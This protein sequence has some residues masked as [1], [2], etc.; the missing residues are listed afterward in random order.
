MT[1]GIDD[2]D[3]RPRAPEFA[4][5]P[6]QEL[7]GKGLA[8]IHRWYLRDLGAVG[9]LMGDI[10]AGLAAPEQ[11]TIPREMWN[12]IREQISPAILAIATI[13][14]LISILLLTAIEM[15]RHRSERLRGMSP[16]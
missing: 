13:L 10:R 1:G 9:A 11:Q 16:R 3:A 15:L 7:N 5:D 14:V 2:P 8:A 12:G 4:L 6:L